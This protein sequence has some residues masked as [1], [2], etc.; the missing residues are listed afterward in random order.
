MRLRDPNTKEFLDA[1]DSFIRRER[2]LRRG[3]D[4]APV[5]VALSGGAD[6]VAL[7]S[8]LI[9][10]GFDCIA[11]HCNFHLRGEES[12]RD[13]RH[14]ESLCDLL[15]VDLYVKDFNV[16]ERMKATGESVEMACRELRYRWFADLLDRDFSQA[17]AVGH[18]REDQAETLMLNLLRGTGIAGLT[19]MK[20][21]NG[22]VVRPFLEVSRKQ[23]EDYL[24]AKGLTYVTD[25]SNASDAHRRN[26]LRNTLFPLMEELFPGAT[27]G[28]LRTISNLVP[29]RGFYDEAIAAACAPFRSGEDG[30]VIELAALS[31]QRHAGIM[32]FEMLRQSGFNATQTQDMLR[33]AHGSGLRFEAADGSGNFAELDRGRLTLNRPA[34]T[35]HEPDAYD[36]DLDRD[37][38]RPVNIAV[39]R[40]DVSEFRPGGRGAMEVCIDASALDGSPRWQLRHSRRGD[41]MA[42]YGMNG[43]KLVSDI[44]S[45][46]K[47][48]AAQKRA[49][50]ILT[51]DDEIMW[52]PGLRTSAHFTIGP[53]TREFIKLRI[54]E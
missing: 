24:T 34:S 3:E 43:T 44:F 2:M 37:I 30:I 6:S 33:S 26:R 51:R 36:I 41:R 8:A 35:M 4:A 1:V 29:V 10:L 21:R 15:G 42:P 22:N 12:M 14:C 17:V 18:H 45:D 9:E 23:I 40:H 7:L 19:G 54:I 20:P 38:L 52:I 5:V 53:S 27:D 13:M 25:S 31:A 11:A 48:S 50:W 47:Y 28:L 49:A 32:L 16:P 39:S 46:A